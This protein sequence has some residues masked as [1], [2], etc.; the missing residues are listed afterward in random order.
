L[1]VVFDASIIFPLLVNEEKSL[2]ARE[3]YAKSQD[4][5]FLD[6]LRVEIAN[7][8]A[9]SVRRRRFDQIYATEAMEKLDRLILR[10]INSAPFVTAAFALA[11][12]I[13]HPVYDCLYAIAARENDAT[14]VTCDVRFAAKL[15]TT[16]YKVKL[17]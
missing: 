14:L 7:G 5:I 1:V 12:E 16:I 11:L 6:F 3:I 4:V 15:D 13:N 9:S 10:A 17:I 8:L 2:V